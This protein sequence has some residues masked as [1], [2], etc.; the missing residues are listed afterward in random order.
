M[1]ATRASSSSWSLETLELAAVTE[2][3]NNTL[4]MAT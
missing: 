1:L 2:F 4:H 3:S